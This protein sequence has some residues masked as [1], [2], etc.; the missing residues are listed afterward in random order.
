MT[1][2]FLRA[3]GCLSPRWNRVSP[4]LLALIFCGCGGSGST[5][6]G[7]QPPPPATPDF[8][9]G[10]TPS[11]VSLLSGGSA[12][13]SLSATPLNGFSSSVAVQL[14]GLP[15]G[16]TVSPSPISLTPGTPVTI[17]FSAATSAASALQSVT[18]SGTSGSLSHNTSLGLQVQA[19]NPMIASLRT[20]YLR[21][22]AVTEYPFWVNTHWVIYD[23]PT[24]RFFFTDPFGTQVFAIDSVTQTEVGSIAVPG[25]YGIDESPDHTTI[26]VGTQIGDVYTIDPVSM[27][28][29]RRYIASKI[30]PYGFQASAALALADGRLALLG[31]QGGIPSVDGAGN[32][33][34]WNPADNSIAVYGAP[35]F[36][37][38]TTVPLCGGLS[39]IGG[40]QL[41][42]DRTAILVG[43][44]SGNGI[45]ELNP[46][47][48]QYIQGGTGGRSLKIVTSPDGRFIALPAVAPAYNTVV[49]IDAH[50]L[51][52]VAEFSV[53]GD[54]SS[55][56][57]LFFSA[58]SRL[59]YVSSE[60]VIYAYDVSTYQQAGWLPNLDVQPQGGGFTVGPLSGPNFGAL[61]STSLLVGPMEEGFGFVD[62][63]T[64]RTGPVGTQFVNAYLYPATGPVEGGTQTEWSAPATVGSQ[65]KVFF[66]G[67]ESPSVSYSGG[68]VI[69]TIPL[70]VP[71]PV[72]VFAFTNDGGMEI[73][74]NGF[75]YGPTILEVTPDST[76][77][78]GGATGVIYGFGFGPSG[79][80]NTPIPSGLHVTVGGKP[81]VVIA[82]NPS[83]YPFI[84]PP[85]PMQSVTY[86]IPAGSAGTADVTVTTSSGSTTAT[87]ALNYL[88][89]A[90]Q[91]PLPGAALAQGIYDP[92]RDLYYFTDASKI[93]V[94]SLAQGKWLTP[95]NIPAPVGATQR[96]WG[97]SL[98][99]DGSKLAVADAQA[100][101]IYL[102]DPAN[103]TSVQTIPVVIP[104]LQPGSTASPDAIAISNSGVAYLVVVLPG[105][106][107][108]YSLDTT[109]VVLTSLGPFDVGAGA[110]GGVG[111]YPKIALS[112]DNTRVYFNE[113]GLV[114]SV[115][116]TTGKYFLASTDP[117][118]C[119]GDYDLTLSEN[120][121][122]LEA[123]GYLYDSDL[124]AESFLTLND[125]E[126]QNIS[127]VYGTKL[128]PDG[129]LLFHPSTNGV[130]VFDGRVGTLRNRLL[131]PFALS[132]NY[133][134]LVED[135]KDN[136]LLAITG[137]TGDGV[138]VLDLSSFIEPRPLVYSSAAIARSTTSQSH[139]SVNEQVSGRLSR[140]AVAA[141]PV[142]GS[143]P[144]RNVPHA[145]N[146]IFLPKS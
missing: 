102:V 54:T 6:G 61:D 84:A 39:G 7:S 34:V 40:F 109:S 76:T 131:L 119:Y 108:F 32:I 8:E 130:D 12:T 52:Q 33:G 78:D 47:T 110:G 60:S 79:I 81:A 122:Q 64:M 11:S 111:L 22:D 20:K 85:Y 90:P 15:A 71:G 13:T 135:G 49:L 16:V 118:C 57:G 45:C 70:G 73:I 145:T 137:A 136:V 115:D 65:S 50:T 67:N 117:G 28:V 116:T 18:F 69:A 125:R 143:I 27:T 138:A 87:A 107:G 141:N 66:G 1:W 92:I 21:T 3:F 75:S 9:L 63:T 91:F 96:L 30:G 106:L 25:A 94:F 46:A 72:D 133:D 53:A 55:A 74:P 103:T 121:I 113:D 42:A 97:I 128:S 19:P 104:G 140:R 23:S 82:F 29:S 139:F 101:V 31:A 99:S 80:A 112:A 95:I 38:E 127:Y 77:A 123:S 24:S 36:N 68:N 62:T 10:V 41:T 37:G 4:L 86:T 56:S 17:T 59:L 89:S 100:D 14:A 35:G 120:Q 44:I 124:N 142:S 144:Y 26:Y 2:E 105:G 88:P 126:A 146:T 93:Q 83:A 129:R 48:G 43:S 58:D 114:F 98:S 5:G 51:A 132:Q 134:A